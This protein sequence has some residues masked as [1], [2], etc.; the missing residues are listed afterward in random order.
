MKGGYAGKF[1]NPADSAHMVLVVDKQK[2]TVFIND[3]Q[4][5]TFEDKKLEGGKLGLTLA[6]GTNKGFGMHCD[7]TNV[8]LWE[9]PE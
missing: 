2:V 3:K 4:A 9:L 6:S 7:M 1:K 8:Q 5:V